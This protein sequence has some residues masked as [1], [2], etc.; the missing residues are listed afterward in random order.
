MASSRQPSRSSR[1]TTKEYRTHR[2][3]AIPSPPHR[4]LFLV[5]TYYGDED[6]LY[7]DVHEDLPTPDWMTNGATD[8]HTSTNKGVAQAATS[9][10]AESSRSGTPAPPLTRMSFHSVPSTSSGITQLFRS[11]SG[12]RIMQR[13]SYVGSPTAR[14]PTT[15]SGVSDSPRD[16]SRR[17][18]R[19]DKRRLKQRIY[20]PVELQVE[21]M[22]ALAMRLTILL[23]Y[24]CL[25]TALVVEVIPSLQ[26]SMVNICGATHDVD[27]RHMDKWTSPCVISQ[28]TGA[29]DGALTTLATVSLKWSGASFMDQRSSLVRY[30]R[31]A[32][33]LPAPADQATTVQVYNLVAETRMSGDGVEWLSEYS[34]SMRCDRRKRRCDVVRVPEFLLGNTPN[35]LSEFSVT[36][37]SVPAS[38]AAG[39]ASGSVGLA[40]QRS[41]YTVA[42]ICWRYGLMFLSLVHTLRFILYRRYTSS[43]YE[44]TWTIVLQM[45][46]LWYMDPLFALSIKKWHLSPVL[47]FLEFRIPTYFM[48][49]L[50][51]YMLSVMTAS[52]TWSRSVGAKP[53]DGVVAKVKAFLMR[54]H[55]VYDPPLWTK[56]LISVYMMSI[57]VLD[58][59]DAFLDRNMWYSPSNSESPFT[60]VH[61]IV[62]ALHIVGGLTCLI[63]LFYLREYLG[64][65][66]YLESRPQQLACRV[67]LMI[68]LSAIAYYVFHCLV[69]L[70]LYNR[71]F[72]AL[73]SQQPFLQLPMLMV[74]SLLV[75]IMTLVYTSQNR[76]ESVPINPKDPRWKHMVWPDTWY[77]WLARHGGSQYIFATEREETRFYRL[78]LDFRW[79]QFM[80]KQKRHRR[81]GGLMSGVAPSHAGSTVATTPLERGGG[82][83]VPCG[84]D[85]RE[86][87]QPSCPS[88][89]SNT[90]EDEDEDGGTSERRSEPPDKRAHSCG[91]ASLSRLDDWLRLQTARGANSV[92]KKSNPSQRVGGDDP[93]AAAAAPTRF[94]TQGSRLRG[95]L[96][97][98]SLNQSMPLTLAARSVMNMDSFSTFFLAD[99]KGMAGGDREG[100]SVTGEDH[101]LLWRQGDIQN[102][103]RV[104]HLLKSYSRSVRDGSSPA[105]IHAIEGP[106]HRR[107][108]LR[109]SVSAMRG[110]FNGASSI[111]MDKFSA[112]R[113]LLATKAMSRTYSDGSRYDVHVSESPPRSGLS[114]L[115]CDRAR[116][117][118][119][120]DVPISWRTNGSKGSAVQNGEGTT[121]HDAAPLPWR[122]RYRDSTADVPMA[123]GT[124][125]SETAPSRLLQK[126]QAA[127]SGTPVLS[128]AAVFREGDADEERQISE[129]EVVVDTRN[130]S[131]AQQRRHLLSAMLQVQTPTKGGA[132]ASDGG[133]RTGTLL[134][135]EER[136]LILPSF[137][138]LLSAGL[139]SGAPVVNDD[140]EV[141][142]RDRRSVSGRGNRVGVRCSEQSDLLSDLSS[143]TSSSSDD[144]NR[145]D[146]THG[147]TRS[148]MRTL[149]MARVRLGALVESA[150]RHLLR[151]PARGLE[152]LEA[153]I[154]DAAYRPFQTIH[155][156][157]FFNLET[158]IDCFNISWQAYGVE[159]STGDHS[160]EMGIRV[161]PQNVPSTVVHCFKK[162]LCGCCAEEDDTSDDKTE[163]ASEGEEVQEETG[164]QDVA[165][166]AGNNTHR[167][168][169]VAP[170]TGDDGAV[171]ET[172]S[173]TSLQRRFSN[174][175]V[176]R[177]RGEGRSGRAEDGTDDSSV[178]AS[179]AIAAPAPA[180]G[181]SPSHITSSSTGPG[182]VGAMPTAAPTTVSESAAL[183]IDVEQYGFVRLL[184]AEASEVQVLMVKM[185]TSASE[186]K[187][188]APRVI[189]GF[190][191]T[192]NMSN[193]RHDMNI[194][195]VVWREME[196]AA[197]SEAA[198]ASGEEVSELASTFGGSSTTSAQY[199]GCA[200]CIRSCIRKTSWRPT[201]HAGFLA[202]WKKLRPTV[203]S[204]LRALLLDDSDT[205]YRIFTTGHSLGGAL[206]S[207]CAFSINCMLKRMDYPIA[208]TTVYTFGQ[209]PMGN[210][211]FQGIY[212]KAVPRTFR[213]V[214]ESDFIAG[215]S[216]FGGYHV[217]I[218]VDVDRHGNYIVKPTEIEKLFPPTKGRGLMLINHL[219]ASYGISLNAIASRTSCP[220]RGLA[221]YLTASPEKIEA[222]RLRTDNTQS[223]PS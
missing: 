56:V 86:S 155:Y 198:S 102:G 154:I 57:F 107:S 136:L 52:M 116:S 80:A 77:R 209:P 202:I 150:E 38:L 184:V 61:W 115:T 35:S 186:H 138:P 219:M 147:G 117:C 197:H 7:V 76:D 82:A 6:P 180:R 205:I 17:R 144:D 214:N 176:A 94:D 204:R 171:H 13:S 54:S 29:A 159:E 133:N 96:G 201:C 71:G 73:A 163:D 98:G 140:D 127:L 64:A 167:T 49:V 129:S 131:F 103:S 5:D 160:I 59:V 43:L 213:I 199:L 74:A 222:K 182:S 151:R 99:D 4:Q 145:S 30:R 112:P 8:C 87:P 12:M 220:A 192:A 101:P 194:H 26:W 148:L 118:L 69:F 146:H 193:A 78:Q 42:T 137:P 172:H 19:L 125:K 122:S 14:A 170:A 142:S 152:R 81:G 22:P 53:G 21:S 168:A 100:G 39:A 79:R 121:G 114:D 9:T 130:N 126:T 135:E 216:L 62:I 97:H 33:S 110:S 195:R 189:I 164:L 36:L 181:F 134:A 1:S 217:G 95:R 158:A 119:N 37:T 75:N 111:N 16:A 143:D 11:S 93:V 2:R 70:L 191:G 40:Y 174:R 10:A 157:P 3:R 63:L 215:M 67:F 27:L 166:G 47:A 183:P 45:A 83:A 72:P 20:E 165:G 48:A 109:H 34:I 139:S 221:L 23:W 25:I 84:T 149:N 60:R 206:A 108:R 55:S 85:V 177:M 123:G 92:A 113:T 32:F 89:A 196:H 66:P 46:L 207:L 24:A 203:L 132:G 50:I 210:R 65:K 41:A 188:K 173:P 68:F 200:S 162:V 185:D 106:A 156:L 218:E 128:Q 51:A 161:R 18:K 175:V 104:L 88:S 178:A 120:R 208:D 91:A 141:K 223:A 211:T 58:V 31:L 28:P 187:G 190:R 15:T 153:Q 124:K 105:D 212:N 169:E 44:Q 179:K 90:D